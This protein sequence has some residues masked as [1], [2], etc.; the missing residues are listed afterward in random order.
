MALSYWSAVH[1]CD[2]PQMP[3]GDAT[4]EL[5]PWEVYMSS[6]IPVPRAVKFGQRVHDRKGVRFSWG[7]PRGCPVFSAV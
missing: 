1:W 2:G 3:F 6:G 5:T 7:F 4:G